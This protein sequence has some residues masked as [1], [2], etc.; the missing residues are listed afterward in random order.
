M[1]LSLL[2]RWK[3]KF[4]S[5][6]S[7]KILNKKKKIF[8][9]LT[10]NLIITSKWNTAIFWIYNG[11]KFIKIS[12]NPN[13]FNTKLGEYAMTRKLHITTKNRKK[14]IIRKK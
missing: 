5:P 11:Q 4:C 2:K 7:I 10:R 6:K 12:I 13:L 1:N 9:T 14:K 8:K 3:F